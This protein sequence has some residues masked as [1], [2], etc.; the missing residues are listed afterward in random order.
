[1]KT[2]HRPNCNRCQPFRRCNGKTPRGEVG[3]ELFFPPPEGWQF[4]ELLLAHPQS[5]Y[6]TLNGLPFEVN[7]DFY[8]R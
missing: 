8:L 2:F 1:M 4:A 7:L 5:T 3:C 6:D